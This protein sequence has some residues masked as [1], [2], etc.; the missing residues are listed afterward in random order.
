M[1]DEEIL[2]RPIGWW[3]KEADARID[4]AFDQVLNGQQV[5]RR[6]WQ[7]MS[8]LARSPARRTD[9]VGSL[10]AFDEPAEVE[11]V[12]D[13]LRARGW[14]EESGGAVRLTLAGL[15]MHEALAPS[16]DQAR[17]RVAGALPEDQYAALI[18]L[19]ARLVGALR[20]PSSESGS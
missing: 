9:I 14:V 2:R 6:D 18:H 15:D 1:S 8:T 16:V 3:L 20:E 10:V 7:V 11:S 4:A 5:G 17:K 19:L 13:G 12:I